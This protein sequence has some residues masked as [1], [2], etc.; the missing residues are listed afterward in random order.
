LTDE[1]LHHVIVLNAGAWLITYKSFTFSQN[2]ARGLR[3]VL[4]SCADNH[5]KLRARTTLLWMETFAANESASDTEEVRAPLR[6]LLA[7]A[8]RM[9][10]LPL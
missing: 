4:K 8:V 3:A 2:F 5:P 9:R 10:V 1:S 7:P 6:L